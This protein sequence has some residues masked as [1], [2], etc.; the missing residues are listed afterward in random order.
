MHHQKFVNLGM[1]KGYKK[2]RAGE[3]KNYNGI[4]PPYEIQIIPEFVVDTAVGNIDECVN[5]A[6]D[7]LVAKELP[8]KSINSCQL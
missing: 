1:F 5:Q 2:A 4:D 3:T 8:Q 7:F 6:L